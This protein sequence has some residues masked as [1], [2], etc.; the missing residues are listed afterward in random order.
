M[1]GKVGRVNGKPRVK[2]VKVKEVRYVN[3][4]KGSGLGK[5]ASKMGKGISR[6]AKSEGWISKHKPVHRIGHMLVNAPIIS[7]FVSQDFKNRMKYGK[8]VGKIESVYDRIKRNKRYVVPAALGVAGTAGLIGAGAKLWDVTHPWSTLRREAS[9]GT[10]EFIRDVA[11]GARN[12][13]R[14][15][16]GKY[17]AH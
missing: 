8:T 16:Y 15:A 10:G 1:I 9:I 4:H 13:L 17:V 6:W 7:S 5:V 2:V 11:K 12:E 14:G 3:R